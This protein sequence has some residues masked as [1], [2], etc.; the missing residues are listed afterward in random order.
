MRAFG[1]SKVRTGGP[2]RTEHAE[3]LH[4][5]PEFGGERIRSSNFHTADADRSSADLFIGVDLETAAR[6]VEAD[7]AQQSELMFLN[8]VSTWTAGQLEN[9]LKRGTWVAVK[10]PLALAVNPA[11]D[12][13][14]DLMHALGGEYSAF[15][16]M[17]AMPDDDEYAEDDDDE[18]DA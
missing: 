10:A 16:A 12:L 14:R 6:A 4:T 1:S 15:S 8:G 17:P 5:N 3:V 2:V 13:W 18:S 7:S 9:E 11:K